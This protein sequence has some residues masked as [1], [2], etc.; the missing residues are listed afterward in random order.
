[1]ASKENEVIIDSGA[2][3]S[4]TGLRNKLKNLRPA[5]CT[6]N[7]AFGETITPSEMGDLPP[8]MLLTIVIEGMKDTTL[9]SVSQAC[10]E[11]MCGI[12]TSRD[13]RFYNLKQINLTQDLRDEVAGRSRGRHPNNG[14]L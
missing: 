5:S 3:T 13:C 6:A 4:G 11:N 14:K 10:A 7:T 8:Y 12:F 2:S 9:L 1:M